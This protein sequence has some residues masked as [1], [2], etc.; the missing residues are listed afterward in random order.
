M[1]ALYLFDCVCVCVSLHAEFT[2]GPEGGSDPAPGGPAEADGRDWLV[3]QSH[4]PG[5]PARKGGIHPRTAGSDPQRAA[6]CVACSCLLQ[7]PNVF[8]LAYVS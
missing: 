1:C 7:V 4:D 6:R 2:G 5:C 3:A 8:S